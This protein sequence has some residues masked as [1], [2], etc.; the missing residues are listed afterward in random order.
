M[1]IIKNH[2]EDE[3]AEKGIKPEQIVGPLYGG[4]K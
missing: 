4:P 1:H 3:A 2:E